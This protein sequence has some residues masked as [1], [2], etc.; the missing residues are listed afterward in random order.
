MDKV[1]EQVNKLSKALRLQVIEALVKVDRIKYGAERLADDEMLYTVKCIDAMPCCTAMLR[2]LFEDAH[3]YH[4]EIGMF[5]HPACIG[6]LEWCCKNRVIGY[7]SVQNVRHSWL[8]L[9]ADDD[10]RRLPAFRQLAAI[11]RPLIEAGKKI[12][13]PVDRKA[14]ESEA[15]AIINDLTNHLIGR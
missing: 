1:Q 4:R 7:A 14:I 6:D 2:R 9:K 12:L 13:P 5:P 15:N 8:P 10:L 11:Y 3:D